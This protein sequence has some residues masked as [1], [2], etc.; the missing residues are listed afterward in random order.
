MPV[1]PSIGLI[2]EGF[3]AKSIDAHVPLWIVHVLLFWYQMQ[4]VCIK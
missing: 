3:F 4:Q 1:K 2:I